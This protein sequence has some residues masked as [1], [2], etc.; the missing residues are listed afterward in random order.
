MPRAEQAAERVKLP[1]QL[2]VAL[3]VFSVD[4]AQ[5]GLCK[6]GRLLGL[7]EGHHGLQPVNLS[8]VALQVKVRRVIRQVGV[9]A[10][11]PIFDR[12]ELTLECVDLFRRRLLVKPK[13]IRRRD[14]IDRAW[15]LG[16]GRTPS[17]R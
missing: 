10:I 16:V 8:L 7:R 17:G 11:G 2:C 6:L 5:V 15:A 9:D 4:P 14:R 3:L 12:L 13:P 1:A